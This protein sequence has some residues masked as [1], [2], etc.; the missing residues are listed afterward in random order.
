[1]SLDDLRQENLAAWSRPIEVHD[2]QKVANTSGAKYIPALEAEVNR[3]R[4]LVGEVE[5]GATCSACSGSGWLLC[6]ERLC[7]HCPRCEDCGVSAA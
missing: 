3:L 5:L 6:G 4:R 2:W 1:M 7:E